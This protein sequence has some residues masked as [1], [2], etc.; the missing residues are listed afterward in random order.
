MPY[1]DPTEPQL[2]QFA[3]GDLAEPF[4]MV[5]LLKFR[6]KAE[7]GQDSGEPERTGAEAYG[8]YG[9]VAME[10]IH[11]VGGRNIFT[12]ANHPMLI[13]PVDTAW[14]MIAIIYYPSRQAFLDMI[15]MPSYRAA[16]HHRTASLETTHVFP[17][18]IPEDLLTQLQHT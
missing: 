7:Y 8:L 12:S 6:D 14:D 9:I 2:V 13:G 10:S 17:S 5:N 18:I 11:A 3:G 4:V 16:L 15:A 1:I